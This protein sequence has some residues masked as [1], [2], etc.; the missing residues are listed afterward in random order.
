MQNEL[1]P[2]AQAAEQPATTDEQP[3]TD[4][5]KRK[6]QKPRT[7]D[8]D[9]LTTEQLLQRLPICRRTLENARAAGRIPYIKPFG[10]KRGRVLYFWPDVR[11]ALQRLQRGG[12]G[13]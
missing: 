8:P 2:T 4:S 5:P 3:A 7:L 13:Q 11:S 6:A 1:Q 12:P 10:A 9:F